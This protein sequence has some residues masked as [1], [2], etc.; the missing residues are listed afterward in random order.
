[1][2]IKNHINRDVCQQA[3]DFGQVIFKFLNACHLFFKAPLILCRDFQGIKINEFPKAG[4]PDQKIHGHPLGKSYHV[5]MGKA[6]G[7]NMLAPAP[8][9]PFFSHFCPGYNLFS[10]VIAVRMGIKRGR[11]LNRRLPVKG[12]FIKP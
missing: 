11:I 12:F 1:M 4:R 7:K 5:V 10:H 3:L 6:G 8:A 2:V 9:I